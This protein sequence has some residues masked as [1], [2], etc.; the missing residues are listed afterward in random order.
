MDDL[1]KGSTIQSLQVGM[2]VLDIIHQ[3]KEPMSFVDICEKTNITKSNLYKYLNTFT[4]LGILYRHKKDGTYILGSKLIEYGMGAANHENVVERVTPYLHEIHQE[5]N[6]TTLLTIWTL[7][8]PMVVNMINKTQG[9]NIGVQIGSTL[10]ILS[11]VGK[12]FAASAEPS[13][14][15]WKKSSCKEWSEQELLTLQ[16]ELEFV[17]TNHISFANEPLVPSISSVAIPVK[18]F[19]KSVLGAIAIVGFSSNIVSEINHPMSQYLLKIGEEI[20]S[21]FGYQR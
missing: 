8:G 11:A 15:E 21:G 12:I 7:H 20:S 9:F 2:H 3:N 1:K 16:N 5:L 13:I 19:K 4:Q 14:E 6:E 18:N 17:R 10:P